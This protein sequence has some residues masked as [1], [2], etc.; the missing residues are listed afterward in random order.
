[1]P[2]E[3]GVCTLKVLDKQITDNKAV[4]L[5]KGLAL[6]TGTIERQQA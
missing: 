3:K 4:V 5:L 6:D 2:E 1:M